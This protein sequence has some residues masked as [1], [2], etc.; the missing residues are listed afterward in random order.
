MLRDL[1]SVTRATHVLHMHSTR[2]YILHC[3]TCL[4]TAD[5]NLAAG[6]FVMNLK[7]VIPL[8]HTPSLNFK[9]SYKQTFWLL[10]PI[11]TGRNI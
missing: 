4:F 7:P 8:K 11:T 1:E 2:F 6:Q 3:R 10:Y 9:R 5:A